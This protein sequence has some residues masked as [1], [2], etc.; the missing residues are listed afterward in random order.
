MNILFI[1]L[2]WPENNESNIYT[3][4]LHEFRDNGHSV[5][6]A[7]TRER[8]INM[9]TQY[10]NEN[11]VNVLRVR[12]GN[13]QKANLIEKGINSILINH[14]MNI[15]I[16]KYLMDISFDLIIY[17]TPPITIGKLIKSLKQRCHAKTYL[18][19]KDIWPQGPADLGAIKENGV[20]W[21]YFRRKEKEIYKVS[22]YIGCMS[23]ANI[24][25]VLD[26]NQEILPER[27]E[28][29]P[30]SVKVREKK[31]KLSNSIRKLYNIPENS[32]L[33]I[34]G[35]NL[36]KPQGISFLIEAASKISHREDIFF[37]II[38][39][40]TE[41]LKIK[42]QIKG[43]KCK[44]I[45]LLERVPK[46]DYELFC[47]DSDVGLILLDNKFTIPNFPSRL[48]TYLDIGMPVLCSTDN[49]CD[50]GDIVEKWNCGIKTLHGDID[51]F[52][53]AV[54]KLARN[55]ELRMRMSKNA[56][57]L[58]EQKYTVKQSYKIIMNHF[59]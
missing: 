22:D 59:K 56:R 44:N 12:C 32:I 45:L 52:I 14:Q 16:K 35:G 51:G 24:K 3:D 55:K 10:L 50:M 18:L 29:C 37:T 40:G 33:F 53:S 15:A 46:E 9:N 26:H 39:S 6:V 2:A 19:L 1:T 58:L 28:E 21:R 5:H 30:N 48:L 41:Y 57:K 20:I 31:P 43:K 49:A 13:I 8:R 17:S 4:L 7:T 34:F 42:E 23:P 36:G 27:I 11:G 47:M 38:G 54:D 25:Y